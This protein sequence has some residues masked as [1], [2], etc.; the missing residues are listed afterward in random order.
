MEKQLELALR[1]GRLRQSLKT[2]FIHEEGVIPLLDNYAFALSLLRSRQVD[3]VLEAK[4]LLEKLLPFGLS[5]HLHEYPTQGDIYFGRKLYPY[6][7]WILREFGPILGVPLRQ[8]LEEQLA[9]LPKPILPENPHT[10]Q[11]WANYLIVCQLDNLDPTPALRQWD[12][13]AFAFIGPQQQEKFEPAVTLFDLFMPELSRRA[14]EDHPTHVRA[15]VIRPWENLVFPADHK[16]SPHIWGDQKHTHSIYIS[17]GA[18]ETVL[19]IDAH[20]DH[21]ITVDHQKATTFQLGDRLQVAHFEVSFSVEGEGK[22]FG[23]ISRGNR[24]GQLSATKFDAYD[25]KIALR[26]IGQGPLKVHFHYT[27]LLQIS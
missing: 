16:T 9:S 17:E 26:T 27:N 1:A 8:K 20:P 19:Y 18:D 6:L 24:P 4:A 3:H 15:S 14:L 21:N 11:E 13:R 5:P 7:F 25:W 12:P 22:V 2:G 10:P 23:H